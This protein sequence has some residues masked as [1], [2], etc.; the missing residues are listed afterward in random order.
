MFIIFGWNHQRTTSYGPV[1]E[2]QCQNCHNTEFWHLSKTSTY[3]TFFFMPVF[4]TDS[5]YWF[6][7][8][9]CNH[10]IKLENGEF[11]NYK[12]IA[13][14]NSAFLENKITEEERIK[15]LEATYTIIDK[16]K[17]DKK[18]KNIEESKNWAKLASEKTNSELLS[19][20]NEMRDEYNPAF[21]IAAELEMEKRNLTNNQ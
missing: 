11:Q 8:P 3:I 6:Y 20:T 12:S 15:Q 1:E 5:S 13:Q 7:C 16:A 21:I 4:P 2:R 14:I 19:I 9:T 10:G 18:V 17:E